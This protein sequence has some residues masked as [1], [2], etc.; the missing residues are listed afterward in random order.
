MTKFVHVA[1]VHI[2]SPM[3]GIESYE[4]L[5]ADEI[6]LAT[7]HSFQ[8][9]VQLCISE[10]AAFLLIAGDLF[11]GKWL[12]MNTGLWMVGQFHQ[13]EVA[14]IRVFLIRGNHDA[15][16]EVQTAL[17]WPANV[18]EFSVDQAET[19]HDAE[20]GIAIHG[21]GYAT[22]AVMDDLAVEY[23][24]AIPNCFNIG[25]LH[26][27]LTGDPD[28]DPYA[29][30]NI[31]V[32]L[33]K[34]YDY[35][36]L[37]HI[38]HRRTL[39]DE[40][41]IGYSG[42]TQGRHI[43]E[44][45]AKGCLL[46]EVRDG[47]VAETEFRATDTVRWHHMEIATDDDDDM[48]V[49]LDKVASAWD[50]VLDDADGRMLIVR[51]TVAGRCRA[52]ATLSDTMAREQFSA[53]VRN[54]SFRFHRLAIEKIRLETRPP[55]DLDRLRNGHDLL[56]DLL[57]SIDEIRQDPQRLSELGDCFRPLLDKAAVEI[58]DSEIDLSSPQEIERW[59]NLTEG[60]LISLLTELES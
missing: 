30:T 46:V 6:R 36:A 23:P 32:L 12:D 31:D 47:S 39:K 43:R 33:S 2:D 51:L 3:R 29:P 4:G 55:V 49:L 37:G 60:R 59:L 54:R 17:R 38:H 42:N 48:E 57:R 53:E 21:R 16:S 45:G 50:T 40:P 9:V 34:A 14:G 56:G 8:N 10:K 28:H 15:A 11:D 44:T 5:P 18:H 41:F 7:R 13:L 1:D 35:W 26:T 27:S 22:P 25:M 20:L 19:F 58:A 24:P 52:H